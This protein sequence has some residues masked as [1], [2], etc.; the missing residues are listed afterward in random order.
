MD[1][2]RDYIIIIALIILF[3]IIVG[4]AIVTFMA[5]FNFMAII[6]VTI[7][8]IWGVIAVSKTLIKKIFHGKRK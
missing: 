7:L 6:F 8:F 1:N 4:I 2:L 5:I 3:A